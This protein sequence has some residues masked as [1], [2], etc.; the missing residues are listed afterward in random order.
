LISFKKFNSVWKRITNYRFT[1][2]NLLAFEGFSNPGQTSSIGASFLQK[3]DSGFTGVG[4]RIPGVDCWQEITEV[5]LMDLAQM[6]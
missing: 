6:A 1:A 3:P 2:G 4:C 5:P